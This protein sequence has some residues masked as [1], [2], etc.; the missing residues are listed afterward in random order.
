M[1]IQ[2]FFGRIHDKRF[3]AIGIFSGLFFI[4]LGLHTHDW[5]LSSLGVLFIILSIVHG[6]PETE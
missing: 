5:C 2:R 3:T 1:N 4:G 6:W